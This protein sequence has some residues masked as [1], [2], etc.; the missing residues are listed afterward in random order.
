M[1]RSFRG[2]A[3]A[4]AVACG[5]AAAGQAAAA[6]TPK[7]S[8][9]TNDDGTT[10]SFAVPATDDP[11]AQVAFYVPADWNTN[12]SLIEGE[13]VGTVQAK[14]TAADLG[15][16]VLP[17]TGTIT[18]AVATTSITFAGATVP[19]SALAAQCGG[20]PSAY[21][22]LN[23]SASGQTL[24]VPIFITNVLAGDPLEAFVAATLR[25]CLPPPDVPAGT[26]GRAAFGAK[27]TEAT[28]NVT[29]GFT[30]GA[31]SRRRTRRGPARGTPPGRSS[32]SRSTASRRRSPSRR[33]RRARR[34]PS[35]RASSPRAA[36]RSSAHPSR[37]WRAPRWSARSRPSPTGATRGP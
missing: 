34:R 20:T 12:V 1:L 31:A 30:S 8:V 15:N 9:S 24:T 36:R 19:L 27:L 29:A 35:S 7:L 3:L 33:K 16:S 21:W 25:I 2:L 23:L 13:P 11:T 28:L 4:A 26:P 14:A 5:L 18:A 17:L 22:L 10:L 37:S 6:Y 32:S